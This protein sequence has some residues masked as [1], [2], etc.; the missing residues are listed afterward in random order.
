MPIYT[1]TGDKGTTGVIGGGRM[2]KTDKLAQAL[3]AI[4]E[5][6]SGMGV[7]RNEIQNS[8]HKFTKIDGELERA[9]NNLMTIASG[10]AGSRKKIRPGEVGHLEKLIDTLTEQMPKLD[11]FIYPVGY[12]QFARAVCRRA[13][14]EVVA[15]LQ[16]PSPV[17]AS[18]SLVKEGE[19][20]AVLKYL[21]RLSDALFTIGRWVNY[22]TGIREE[23]WR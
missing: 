1:R 8:N 15:L 13:E 23:K 19:R 7:C 18:P 11:K 4:D 21:N 14:R 6:N 16:T 10:L 17:G 3:G 5:A 22:Q 12:L 20:E 2:S 9:Q